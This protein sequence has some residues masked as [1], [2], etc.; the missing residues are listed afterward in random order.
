[1]KKI[2]EHSIGTTFVFVEIRWMADKSFVAGSLY[3]ANGNSVTSAVLMSYYTIL[4][5]SFMAFGCVKEQYST[6]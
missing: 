3:V 1:M 6:D 2:N 5:L 4:V